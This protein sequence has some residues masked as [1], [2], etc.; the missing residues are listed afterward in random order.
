LSGSVTKLEG[1]LAQALD[2]ASRADA[3]ARRAQGQSKNTV[4]RLERELQRT[5]KQLDELLM[6][7][8]DETQRAAFQTRRELDEIKERSTAA[9][10]ADAVGEFQEYSG[11][12]L[13]QFGVKNEDPRLRAAFD[14]Y[15]GDSNDPATWRISLSQAIA[16][17]K[18]DDA[19][20]AG[21]SVAERERLAREEER[22]RA[23]AER[24]KAGGPVDRGAPQG[25]STKPKNV[26]EMSDEEFKDFEKRKDA[27]VGREPSV[28]RAP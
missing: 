28:P 18:A 7:S 16:D 22:A 4:Q 6:S 24:R 21:A 3:S 19:K 1:Q 5:N 23:E 26:W 27:S 10:E 2:L 25:G 17:V 11:R 12:I 9:P 20:Q 14:R 15:V 13:T 8:M